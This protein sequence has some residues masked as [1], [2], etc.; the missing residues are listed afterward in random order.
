MIVDISLHCVGLKITMGQSRQASATTF[1]HVSL[2][3]KGDD[4]A[5][6]V[7]AR[8][9]FLRSCFWTFH[10]IATTSLM[11]FTPE[12]I[13]SLEAGFGQIFF[14]SAVH[15]VSLRVPKHLDSC[16]TFNK[17]HEIPWAL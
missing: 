7:R 14:L 15:F 13:I 11:G 12:E 8:C 2:F 16:S 10:S 4:K 1:P 5:E 17:A 3:T 6:T 9:C